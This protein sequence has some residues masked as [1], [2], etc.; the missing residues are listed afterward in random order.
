M[1]AFLIALLALL[2]AVLLA[3]AVVAWLVF[4]DRSRPA[5][6][7]T[8]DVPPGYGI[9]H[10]GAQ[11]ETAG[12][13][14]SGTLLKYYAT[15]RG[16]AS[17]VNA[18][19]YEFPANQSLAE[20]VDRLATGGRP[21]VVWVTIP[22]GYTA[23]QIAHRLDEWQITPAAAFED[24]AAHNS[25]LIDGALTRGLEGFL[26]PD[27]YQLR[28]GSSAQD[29]ASLMTDQFRKKLPKDA[30]RVA[31]KLGYSVPEIITL[32][33]IIERE[34]KVDGERRLMAG[35][36]YN[37]LKRGMPLEVDATIEYALPVHKTV[38]H[39]RDL[40]VDSP[41]NTYTHT[42]LPPTPIANPGVRSIDAALHPAHTDYLYYVYAGNGRH[43]FSRTLQEQ[44]DAVRRYLH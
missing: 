26:Y 8:V 42:G 35:V 4:G 29:V 44:Q 28:R 18:A 23:R 13:V 22:E 38:L 32:A 7:V 20:V 39:Y 34:A 15:L 17:R 1:R 37:R 19:E 25:L 3:T 12:V 14:R 2:G 36:Y 43:H 16:V 31:R 21:P 40:E 33:S 41:Y 24:V 10:I 9:G 6:P 11:L 27:T 5:A 30:A